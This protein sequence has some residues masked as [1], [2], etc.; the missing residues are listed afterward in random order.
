VSTVLAIDQ[1][2]SGTKA[3]VHDSVDGVLG[4]AEAP[5][6]PAYLAGGGVE[7][8]PAELLASVLDA[9]RRAVA[10]AGRPL[11][12]VSLANQGETVLAWD[13]VSGRPLSTAV[14]WQDRRAESV[15]APLSDA[16]EWVAQRTGLV[17]DSYFSAPKMAW[18]RR[19][20]T[21]AGVVTTTDTWLV[22]RLAGVFVTDASTASRSLLTDLDSGRWDDDLL[23]LFGLQDE[24]LPRIAASDEI[25]GT[26]DAFGAE[27][28]V[29]GLIVD[30]QAALLAQG[31]TSAGQAKCTFG[32]GAFLLVNTEA[33][34][35]RSRGGLS[36]SV[37]WR[38]QDQTSYCLDGQVFTA[39]SAVR[40]LI[41][42]G[43]I[44]RVEDIDAM[45][46]PEGPHGSGADDVLC[47]PALAGL[48][49]PWWRSDATASFVGMT[50]STRREDLV[51]AVVLGIA[52]QLAELA[53]V[54]HADVGRSLDRLRVDGGLVRCRTLMQATADLL[55][56][57][58]DVYP[59]PHA[60]ALGAA[61]AAQLALDPA[62]TLDQAVPAWSPALTY[63][64]RWSADRA[65][66]YV[67]RWRATVAATVDAPL[68]SG[69]PA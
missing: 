37:A 40:W 67:R 47:V 3:L 53:A 57:P 66:R 43:L 27:V 29:G 63:E 51:R 7:Q 15:V 30:Q 44:N 13:P 46:S 60:T 12:G 9:G 56:V 41:D 23:A 36:S 35:V 50:L 11:D 31:A 39:A 28:P 62:L 2:T 45:A 6:R 5:V 8:D 10:A 17:L 64:P 26:T 22:H 49:A 18:L 59:H 32:T 61:A 58:V 68:G 34:A 69:S 16:R 20:R 52:A 25:V 4:V 38:L 14:V 65:E 1:G 33:R 42:L 19:N 55:R 54:V 21:R 48:G 24:R